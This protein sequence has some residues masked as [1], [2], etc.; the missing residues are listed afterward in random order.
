MLPGHRAAGNVVQPVPQF[1]CSGHPL[2]LGIP[3]RVP[4]CRRATGRPSIPRAGC[5]GDHPAR[6]A[7]RGVAWAGPA[8]QAALSCFANPAWHLPQLPAAP[9]EQRNQLI[10]PALGEVG[11]ARQALPL[12]RGEARRGPAGCWVAGRVSRPL[13]GVPAVPT[14]W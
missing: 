14:G 1:P 13:P 12:T 3:L 2:G 7:W 6:V 8:P 9:R 5:P 11:Q 10:L 4:G